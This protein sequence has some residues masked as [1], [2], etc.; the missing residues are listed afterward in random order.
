MGS[1]KRYLDEMMDFD[2]IVS[3]PGKYVSATCFEDKHLRQ[4]IRQNLSQKRCSYYCGQGKIPKGAPLDKVL[5]VIFNGFCSRYDD[6]TNGVGW[7]DGFVGATTWDSYDLVSETIELT[8]KAEARLLDDII[9]ALPERTWSETD[10]YGARDHQILRWSWDKFVN[11]VKH[12]RRFYFDQSAT[13]GEES[14]S[15][16]ELLAEVASKCKQARML[17]KLP[18]GTTFYRCRARKKG[19]H[20]NEPGELGPP[21]KEYA[22]QSRMSPAGIPMFYGAIDEAT[23]RAE[24]LAADDARHSM[25][26]F[27]LGRAVHVLDLTESTTISL[28]DAKRQSFYDWAIFMQKFRHDIRRRVK[29]DDRIHIEYVPTQIV[30]EYFRSFLKTQRGKPIDGILYRSAT[31]TAKVCVALFADTN[32]VAPTPTNEGKQ[33]TASNHLLQLISLTEHK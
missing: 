19:E 11:V 12:E 9:G 14:I 18:S 30:T 17:R 27:R 10:P 25:A 32:D 2:R 15:P 16:G 22:S 26:L 6:A 13:E 3:Q 1:V 4:Y 7:E 28:F 5:A 8:E 23:A 31:H 29:K 33:E 21:P 20:F 24:T